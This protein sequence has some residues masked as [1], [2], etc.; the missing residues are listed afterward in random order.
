MKKKMSKDAEARV[1]IKPSI[2]GAEDK[3]RFS[4]VELTSQLKGDTQ[5]LNTDGDNFE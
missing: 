2:A 1:E 3:K 5:T 4:E